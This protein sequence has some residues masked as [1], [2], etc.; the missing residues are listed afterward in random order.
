MRR[1]FW[2]FFWL[3]IPATASGQWDVFTEPG[4]SGARFRGNDG[5]LRGVAIDDSLIVGRAI[6]AAQGVAGLKIGEHVQ[7]WSA[8]L[9]SLAVA[10]VSGT[11]TF[12]RTS[13]IGSVLQG[14]HANLQ[15]VAGLASATD[16]VPYF[17][18][19]GTAGLD[20][21]TAYARRFTDAATAAAA[22]DT[23]GLGTMAIQNANSVA[24]TGGTISGLPS[25]GSGT[26]PVTLDY[27]NANPAGG[28]SFNDSAFEVF[29]NSDNTKKV[30]LSVVSVTASTTRTLTVPD[31]S[32]NLGVAPI[33][34]TDL[35]NS[36]ITVT[37]GTGLTTGGSV[38]LGGSVTVNLST[39]VA[40][41]HGGTA[42]NLTAANGGIVYSG[43]AALAITSAGSS[44]QILKSAG[45]AAPT[46]NT[47]AALTKTDDTN[48][49]LTLGGSP[50]TA[51]VN[52]ASITAGWTGTLAVARGGTG[53][54]DAGTART[55]LGLAIGT[56]V[57]A[58]H[59]NLAAISAGTWTGA[60]SITTLGTISTGTVPVANISGLGSL[61]TLSSVNDGNWSG[62]DLAVANGG[63]GASDA[64]TARTNLGLAIGTNVQ[65]Y[66]AD[67]SAIASANN[68]TYLN[69]IGSPGTYGTISVTGINTG[70]A[71]IAF[72]SATNTPTLMVSSD[73]NTIGFYKQGSSTWNWYWSG[74]TLTTGT[75]P[76]ANISGLGS[77]ATLSS[78]NNS[79]WS[80]TALAVG[81][82]GTGATDAGTAR[83][84]LG[85]AIG[86]NVQ[87]YSANLADLATYG[88]STSAS[89]NTYV[90]RDPN[91][92]ILNSYFNMTADVTG[93]GASHFA[94]ATNSDNYLRWQTP[95][96]ARTSLGLGSLATLSSISNDN[97][98]GT[99]L[100]VVNGGTGASDA[101]T[102]RSNL[103]LA[104]GSNV[105]AYN[106]TLADV[107]AKG[108]ATANTA[109]TY[110]LR[111]G[112]ARFQ[113]SDPSAAQDV[114][115]KNYVDTQ[116]AGAGGG[117]LKYVKSTN[118]SSTNP[119]C[120]C[121]SG[122]VILQASA[123]ATSDGGQYGR[124]KTRAAWT[125]WRS[126]VGQIDDETGTA[127]SASGLTT[128]IVAGWD[129]IGTQSWTPSLSGTGRTCI[130]LCAE[131]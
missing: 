63:T 87:A 22:R 28:S 111:D 35:A 66:D 29:N 120:D 38:S 121:G 20:V 26:A 62:T 31:R 101:G 97:W 9:D 94:I 39:P 93:T 7:A 117:R 52:A 102:A 78:V 118:T 21:Y 41:S 71:G 47:A 85:L 54:S 103:G 68:S 48:V 131:Q 49:T 116:I 17:T 77:L 10:G 124:M 44:G 27:F 70:Y 91:G 16:R 82:G 18:G 86:S 6:R 75:V 25:P 119:V 92:Y 69:T 37:A 12:L 61:A 13:L 74:G 30:K 89:A 128:S 65:A 125:V 8:N 90:K 99:D 57:Q 88:A 64:G 129:I 56:N 130:A 4:G 126:D 58:Y 127:P 40:L 100:A 24:I 19:S 5:N 98:S 55:N 110:V 72:P 3:L 11:G 108:S 80:G 50:S 76:V 36:A 81:N 46:W 79:N 109:S 59:A 2:L 112:S 106:A 122:W 83:S 95:T 123:T 104:I 1:L 84:N 14:Y 33:P 45:A 105:Q 73:G 34:N 113:A 53:A 15:A 67:L 32:G 115:T 96:N 60:S 23:L 114:A 43:A 107:A 42:A 51:L